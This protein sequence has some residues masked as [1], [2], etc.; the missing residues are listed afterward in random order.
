MGAVEIILIVICSVAVIGVI[1]AAIYKK[2]KGIPSG[3][4]C[5]C[6]H[7]PHSCPSRKKGSGHSQ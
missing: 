5:G 4:D 1:A 2:V 7:C 3:C 6:A